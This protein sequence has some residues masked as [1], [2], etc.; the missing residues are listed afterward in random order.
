[1]SVLDLTVQQMTQAHKGLLAADESNGT[2]GKRLASINVE[3]TEENRRAYRELLLTT[4]K[5]EE[6]ISGVILYEETLYQKTADG[7]PFVELLTEKGVVPGIKVDK[8][9][10]P[11]G[12]DNRE[13]TTQGFEDLSDRCAQYFTDG[14]RFAKWR[15]TFAVNP[16]NSLPSD[17]AVTENARSLA[18][19]AAICQENELV[20]IVEP[21]VL[22]EGS[23]TMQ[24]Y[25]QATE[26]VQTA[27]FAALDEF[28]V[29]LH[30]I[31]LKPNMIVPSSEG[32][33]EMDYNRVADMTL[34]VLHTC[35]PA[36]VPAIM[37][38]SGGQ[39]EEDAEGTL[40]AINEKAADMPWPLTFSY[41]R[42]L[43]TSA[44][45]AWGGK[46]EN[47]HAAQHAFQERAHALSS[48]VK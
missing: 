7:K 41:G 32:K 47:A 23:F 48:I 33:E 17:L 4:E 25:A 38:L 42:A 44:L 9:V 19:Y 24:E 30:Q 37:F 31:I 1:M 27:V 5:M 34:K 18:R 13:D 8:G 22:M 35:V 10:R 26:R 20:P 11:I 29:A 2:A 16:T 12:G 15:A 39:S 3:N 45:Q 28:S 43:Q 40:K 6:A 46:V 36:D 21:E 14:A